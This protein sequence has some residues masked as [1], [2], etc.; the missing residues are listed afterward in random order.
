M[1]GK[2]GVLRCSLPTLIPTSQKT[3]M[4]GQVAEIRR[5][6][7]DEQKEVTN[8]YAVCSH[9]ICSEQSHDL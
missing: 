1:R 4:E 6:C 8:S 7:E 2:E 9:M 5:K 3:T